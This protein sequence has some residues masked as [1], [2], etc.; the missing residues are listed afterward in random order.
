MNDEQ[1]FQLLADVFTYFNLVQSI[2]H[3]DTT[4]VR[5]IKLAAANYALKRVKEKYGIKI[6]D[7][8]CQ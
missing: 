2:S 8:D 1:L 7:G 5:R 6:K 4:D 3:T